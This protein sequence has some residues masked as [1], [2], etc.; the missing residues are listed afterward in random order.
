MNP[1]VQQITTISI[2]FWQL[3]SVFGGLISTGGLLIFTFTRIIARLLEKSFK[4]RDDKLTSVIDKVDEV[5]RDLL[6]MRSE[7]PN[8]YVRRD[9]W[10]RFSA[11][12][13]A[14]LDSLRDRGELTHNLLIQAIEQW[15]VKGLKDNER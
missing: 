7:L 12:I 2:E 13:D 6:R 10:I 14:K 9:D 11:V 15:R 5:E 1:P 4:E 8:N 3:C